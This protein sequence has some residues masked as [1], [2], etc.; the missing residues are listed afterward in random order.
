MR[1]VFCFISIIFNPYSLILARRNL[2]EEIFSDWAWKPR[3]KI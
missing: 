1:G 3:I 2:Y